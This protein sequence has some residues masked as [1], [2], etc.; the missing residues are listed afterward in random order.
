M[1]LSIQLSSTNKPTYQLLTVALTN[2]SIPSPVTKPLV[3]TQIKLLKVL[4]KVRQMQHA[5][6]LITLL[7]SDNTHKLRQR[8]HVVTPHTRLH[9]VLTGHEVILY[10]GL[11]V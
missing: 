2:F 7:Y 8:A 4:L 3:Y 1:Y 9:Y 5:H 11:Y 10:V 6:A